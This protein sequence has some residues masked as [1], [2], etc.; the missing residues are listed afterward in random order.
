MKT[1]R[2][3]GERIRSDAAKAAYPRIIVFP[4]DI[5]RWISRGMHPWWASNRVRA[6]EAGEFQVAN[7]RPGRYLVAAMS[8]ERASLV[9]LKR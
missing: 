2:H 7:L 1:P 6:N 5:E 9:S 4:A 8:T 3:H